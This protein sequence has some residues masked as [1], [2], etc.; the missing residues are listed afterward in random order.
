MPVFAS[1][2]KALFRQKSLADADSENAQKVILVNSSHKCQCVFGALQCFDF[3]FTSHGAI[4]LCALHNVKYRY[5]SEK[6]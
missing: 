3:A 4:P 2:H 6:R 5:P 1:N